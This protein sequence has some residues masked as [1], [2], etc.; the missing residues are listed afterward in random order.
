MIGT[1]KENAYKDAKKCLDRLLAN[2]QIPFYGYV[3]IMLQLDAM[4]R[5]EQVPTVEWIAREDMDYLDENKVVHNHFE[6]NKCG[7]IHDFLDGH[8]SQ[9]N[10]CPNCGAKMERGEEE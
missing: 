8:T 9:Y 6:Y 10:F 4:K 3:E 1:N 5:E 7:F 2:D